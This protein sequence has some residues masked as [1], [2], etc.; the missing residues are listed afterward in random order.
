[1]YRLR[2]FFRA[3]GAWLAPSAWVEVESLLTPAEAVLFRR[4]PRYDQRHGLDV[5]RALRAAGY[6]HPELLVAALLHDVAKS[7]GPLR[8]WHR[9]AIVLLRAFAPRRL[10]RLAREV[11]PGHWRYPFY[12]HRVH[13]EVSARWVEEAGGSF[14]TVWLIGR[15][16]LPVE[17]DKNGYDGDENRLLAA[18]QWADDQN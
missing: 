9:A 17:Q 10:A 12:L 13:A 5:V 7:A 3:L 8:L 4:M 16:Q 1:M 11:E 18:L 2:Q 15:H 14:L 6:N